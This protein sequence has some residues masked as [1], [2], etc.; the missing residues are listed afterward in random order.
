MRKMTQTNIQEN[1]NELILYSKPT[2]DVATAVQP[3]Q[4]PIGTIQLENRIVAD[5]ILF[6]GGFANLEVDTYGV[7]GRG[8]LSLYSANETEE[9]PKSSLTQVVMGKLFGPQKRK[10]TI[11]HEGTEFKRDWYISTGYYRERIIWHDTHRGIV[12]P[13]DNVVNKLK[14]IAVNEENLVLGN[15]MLAQLYGPLFQSVGKTYNA[16]MRS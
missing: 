8:Y 3:L 1:G 14:E 6:I 11:E 15:A 2:F 5:D 4:T 12:R 16:V 13:D 7:K 10:S 9:S